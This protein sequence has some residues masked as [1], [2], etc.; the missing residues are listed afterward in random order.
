MKERLCAQFYF[1]LPKRL[2]RDDKLYGFTFR[3]K[4]QKLTFKGQGSDITS[5]KRMIVSEVVPY[6]IFSLCGNSF[7]LDV[8]Q[9]SGPQ[10]GKKIIKEEVYHA[11]AIIND[12]VHG[13]YSYIKL[14]R[15]KRK[16]R[17][18]RLV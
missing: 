5:R 11:P 7:T 3:G 1:I 14:F 17:A 4:G 8:W 2:T 6:G 12:Y 10:Q 16:V 9:I 13:V 18:S 15:D